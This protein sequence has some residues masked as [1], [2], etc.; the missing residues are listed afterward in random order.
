MKAF[1]KAVQH[2]AFPEVCPVCLVRLQAS[3]LDVCTD[4][5]ELLP[6]LPSPRCPLCGGPIDGALAACSECLR[7]DERPWAHAVSV[8]PFRGPARELIHRFKYQG[9]TYLAPVLGARMAANWRQYGDCVPDALVPVPLHWTRQ[10]RRGF[11]QAEL[12]AQHMCHGL[13]IPVKC[14]LSRRRR[15]AQQAMLDFSERQANMRDVFAVR[16]SIDPAGLRVLLVDD[17]MTTGAT[18]AAVTHVLLAT[19]VAAVSVI[20]AARG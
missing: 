20:T 18:L 1:L 16:R 4:C 12:L 7:A 9:H 6:E 14:L 8:F 3:G 11:N 2:I 5:A 13:Q 10:I 17:V 15:T 19:N